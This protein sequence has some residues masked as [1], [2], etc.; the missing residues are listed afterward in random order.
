MLTRAERRTEAELIDQRRRTIAAGLLAGISQ[1]ELART[2]NVSTATVSLDAAAVKAQWKD[3]QTA[4]YDE[5]VVRQT[6]RLERILAQPFRLACS[7]DL[8]AIAAVLAIHD[9]LVKILG[10]EAV[11]RREVTV[12]EE[13]ASF[14]RDRVEAIVKALAAEPTDDTEPTDQPEQLERTDG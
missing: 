3:E 2:L 6:A 11:E 1:A 10:I 9:R 12:T 4:T 7:G 8:K 5:L 14:V 13:S